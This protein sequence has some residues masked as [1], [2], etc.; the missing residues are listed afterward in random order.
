MVKPLKDVMFLFFPFS[1]SVPVC[2]AILERLRL[3]CLP[4]ELW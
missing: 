4:I 1:G 2:F 3:K